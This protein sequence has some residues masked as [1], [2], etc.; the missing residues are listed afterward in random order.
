MDDWVG[1]GGQGMVSVLTGVVT[2]YMGP[3][4]RKGA[5]CPQPSVGHQALRK[6]CWVVC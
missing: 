1:T 4:L 2:V 6:G 5:T 3:F